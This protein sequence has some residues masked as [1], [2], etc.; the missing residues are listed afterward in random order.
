M[1]GEFT[2]WFTND[3]RQFMAQLLKLVRQSEAE[4]TDD[5]EQAFLAMERIGDA[6][7]E[8]HGDGSVRSIFDRIQQ[9]RAVKHERSAMLHRL[10]SRLLGGQSGELATWLNAADAEFLKDVG[11]KL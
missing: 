10:A 8:V 3:E 1:T 4:G 9:A 11:I 7:D 2:H 5:N 6:F